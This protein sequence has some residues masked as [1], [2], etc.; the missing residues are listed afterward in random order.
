MGG[1]AYRS[2]DLARLG[3]PGRQLQGCA[4]PGP[5]APGH[6]G[7]AG[8]SCHRLTVGSGSTSFIA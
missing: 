3:V 4:A 1:I 6:G 8:R 5:A 2:A 7:N